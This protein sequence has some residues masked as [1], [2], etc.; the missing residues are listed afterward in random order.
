MRRRTRDRWPIGA[1]SKR[2][3]G[4]KMRLTSDSS[5]RS[6]LRLQGNKLRLSE[7]LLRSG[8]EMRKLKR[9]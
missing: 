9:E 7:L 2:R 5:Y 1:E 6:W 8:K 3:K 4:R